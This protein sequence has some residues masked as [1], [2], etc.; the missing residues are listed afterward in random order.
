MKKYVICCGNV[1]FDLISYSGFDRYGSLFEARPG[2]SVLNTA[3]HL[4][5]LGLPVIMLSKTSKDI[6]GDA[7]VKIMAQEKIRTN[8]V[9]QDERIKTSLAVA[10]LDKKGD[11]SYIFYKSDGPETAFKKGEIPASLFASAFS[12]HSGSAYTYDDYTFGSTLE[13]MAAARK[14]R[15]FTTY[16]PNWREERIRD[17]PAARRRI[18]KLLEF[19]S[20]LKLSENDLVSIT[21]TRTLNSAL[22]KIN[23]SAVVTLGRKGS[24]YWD[25]KTKIFCPAFKVSVIDTIGAG[26]AFTAGLIYK[27]STEG[28]KAFLGNIGETLRFSSCVSAAVCSGKGANAGL[29]N[30]SQIKRMLA[31]P[32]KSKS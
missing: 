5:R 10:S 22:S 18:K 4:S 7:I 3:I 9:F 16:D 1:A 2:G 8:Y 24:F 28:D 26:D 11:S 13:L 23:R 27:Y 29:R 19:T 25:G 14:A 32:A 20:L 17:K 6:L 30:L 21:G 12:L 31:N 15:I